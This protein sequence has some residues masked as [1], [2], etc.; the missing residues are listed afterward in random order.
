M[1][2]PEDYRRYKWFFTSSGKL[3]IGGKSALQNEE[4]LRRLK[5]LKKEFIVMH[6][7]EPGSP[8]SIIFDDLKKISA[9][10]LK[11]CAIFT[12]CFS[13]A[14]R[15]GEKKTKIGIF[16]LSQLRKNNNMKAGT[17]EVVGEVTEMDV[18]LE[19]ALTKQSGTIRAVPLESIKNKKEILLKISPGKID[20]KDAPLKLDFELKNNFSQEEIL[21]ALPAGG[22]KILR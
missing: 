10:D 18:N 7:K 1:Q 21:S 17:W 8:F 20:K 6:T 4:L 22:F 14:W 16:K 13:R 15:S 3:V 2:F 12:G 11:E 19:L 5:L 9:S